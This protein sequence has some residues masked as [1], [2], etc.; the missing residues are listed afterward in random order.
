M[1]RKPALALL[2]LGPGL[3]NGLCNLHNARRAWTPVVVG[4][5]RLH[6]RV[7][8]GGWLGGR[9]RTL[10]RVRAR[11]CTHTRAPACVSKAPAH[12]MPTA[13]PPT[14]ACEMRAWAKHTKRSLTPQLPFHLPKTTLEK[15]LAPTNGSQ[16]IVGDMATWHRAADPV[17]N[18]DIEALA[19]TQGRVMRV[20]SP[21]AA[22]PTLAAAVAAA[23]APAAPEGG[24]GEG[25]GPAGPSNVV[26]VVF[27]H[28]VSWQKAV[29]AGDETDGGVPSGDCM[30]VGGPRAMAGAA[31]AAAGAAVAEAG[32][33]AAAP[34]SEGARE[35]IK[36][37]AKVRACVSGAR[38][39]SSET[40]RLKRALGGSCVLPWT[41]PHVPCVAP[42]SRRRFD[43]SRPPACGG[44]GL[45]Q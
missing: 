15:P 32:V 3:G 38:R 19:A 36:R 10:S 44:P 27:P 40:C 8:E 24:G 39:R 11:A 18:S 31:G 20:A 14:T 25:E 30:V 43:S 37:C 17:L 35:F 9:P 29:A 26:T 45:R 1:A 34:Q 4:L 41:R 22:G 2:H 12:R 42:R 6:V 16:V 21:A 28:D 23:S 7:R 33:A 5:H 13:A